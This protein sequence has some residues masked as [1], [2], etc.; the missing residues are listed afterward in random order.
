MLGQQPPKQSMFQMVTIDELV[1]EDHFLRH[2]DAT[3]DLSFIRERVR[4]L[5]D[6]R[7]GRPSVD[8]ELALRMFLLSYLFNLSE[9][10]LCAEIGMHAGYR[11]FCRLDF[12]DPVPDRTTLVK[13]R[14]ER[15]GPA[16]I[17][18]DLMRH[19]VT[20]C[21]EAGLVSGEVLAVDGTL[22]N[23]RAS[24]QSLEAIEPPV[25]LESYL[26]A[27]KAADD[28]ERESNDNPPED[29]PPSNRKAGDPN[30]RGERFSNTTH[31]SK[32]D[33]DARLYSK[34]H[35][36]EAKL[37]YIVHDLTDV[38]SCVILKT[39]ATQCSGNAERYAAAA[40]L[41]EVA[42]D[43]YDTTYLLADGG[44][45]TNDFLETVFSL[46]INPLVPVR[47]EIEPL[48]VWQRRTSSMDRLRKRKQKYRNAQVR[49]R[50]RLLRQSTAYD[51]LYPLRIRQEHRFAEAKECHG[52][53]RARG[54]GLLAMDV[55]AK[56]TATVQNLKRLVKWNRRRG[57][58]GGQVL[59]AS[60]TEHRL[61]DPLPCVAATTA[62]VFF[63]FFGPKRRFHAISAQRSWA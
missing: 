8:P 41:E 1:P 51:E 30:F 14:R 59:S 4:N 27:T 49:N 19:V 29:P 61:I 57:K 7:M 11:W 50:A 48:P 2:L 33:P 10:R 44:Y 21:V 16:G 58:A 36:Q 54:C 9:N 52:M 63:S 23:A 22:V 6:D 31:R 43:G 53:D 39:G 35:K 24:I 34:D 56:L 28:A 37:R 62:N 47:G 13:L 60:N 5:Y 15:W 38:R 26:K 45:T 20:A 55:Q 17:F 46:G 3:I 40:M 32:T 12:H 18:D 25:S 42:A